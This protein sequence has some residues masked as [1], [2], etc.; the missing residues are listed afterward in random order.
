MQSKIDP[1]VQIET[2]QR[3]AKEKEN[4]AHEQK[5]RLEKEERQ[6]ME[7]KKERLGQEP[8]EDSETSVL[9][10]F[11]KPTGNERIQRRF[12]KTDKVERLYDFIDIMAEK[13]NKI[14]FEI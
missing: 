9:I 13:D 7:E 2:A 10:V 1:K 6:R 4:E 11:R 14:G 5:E 3:N 12:R 8:E